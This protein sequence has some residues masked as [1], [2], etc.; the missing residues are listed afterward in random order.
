MPLGGILSAGLPIVSG[1]IGNI[2]GESDRANARKLQQEALQRILDVHA[3]TVDSM[4]LGLDQYQSAGQ[5]DPAMAE[6]VN[7]KDSL[8][9]NVSTDPRLR[10]AQMASLNQLQQMGV[11]G[12][13][14]EDMAAISSVI[15][16]TNQQ[17]NA[18]NQAVLQNMQ[19]RGIGGSGNELAAKMMNNQNAANLSSQQG[20]D[21]AGQASQRALQAIMSAGSMGSSMEGQ[22]FNQDAQKA[23]AQD[24]INKYNSMNQ[25]QITNNNT[26]TRNAAQ[27]QNLAN[28]QSLM[29]S[30]VGLANQQQQYNKGLLQQDF[31]NQLNRASV[32]SGAQQKAAD[33]SNA[34][35]AQTGKMWSDV[36]TGLATGAAG[37]GNYYNN[38]EAAQNAAK[39]Q[40][41]QNDFTQQNL[42]ILSGKKKV[43]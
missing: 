24:I 28:K 36:G 8:I 7:A 41:I 29:N 2:A 4:K 15:N 37:V 18:A 34:Q 21:V 23:Q 1:L 9:N 13:R 27:A 42:D 12:M 38:Q 19:Q 31:S 26:S 22:Q 43:N 3:P 5:L 40:A 16:K 17:S 6:T 35:A 39:Q 10:A 25:Q 20:L 33:Q 32:A 30:N 11:S 14:P